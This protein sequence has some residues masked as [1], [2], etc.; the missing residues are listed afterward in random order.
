MLRRLREFNPTLKFIVISPY[1][2]TSVYQSALA[3]GAD[4]FVLQR[5]I[6]TDLLPAVDAVRAGQRFLSPS[7]LTSARGTGRGDKPIPN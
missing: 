6:A 3:A 5:A 7:T 4:G 2:E 1:D